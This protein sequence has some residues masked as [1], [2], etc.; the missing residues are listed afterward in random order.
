ACTVQHLYKNQI[1]KYWYYGIETVIDLVRLLQYAAIMIIGT[2]AA[3]K[4][5]SSSLSA[6]GEMFSGIHLVHKSEFI[7]DAIGFLILLSIYK[8]ILFLVF[9]KSD[10]SALRDKLSITIIDV[11]TLRNLIMI[12][13]TNMF[14]LPVFAIYLLQILRFIP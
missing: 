5:L 13:F 3:V 10:L 8:F 12:V 14:V 1:G 2:G 6:W 9:N 7:W 11:I 4:E